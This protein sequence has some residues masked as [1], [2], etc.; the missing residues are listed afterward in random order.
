MA[1]CDSAILALRAV[2]ELSGRGLSDILAEIPGGVRLGVRGVWVSEWKPRKPRRKGGI[3][4]QFRS[5][6]RVEG[7]G[8]RVSSDRTTGWLVLKAPVRDSIQVRILAEGHAAREL[9]WRT[10]PCRAE[11]LVVRMKWSPGRLWSPRVIVRDA[12]TGGALL[13]ARVVDVDRPQYRAPI[14][15]DEHGWMTMPG[16]WGGQ[17]V[18]LEASCYQYESERCTVSLADGKVDTVVFRLKRLRPTDGRR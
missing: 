9:L 11:T 14:V 10:L 2:D 16:I 3:Y 15:V 12:T 7:D 4:L 5:E 18:T 6:E 1:P 13:G 17:A 8:L